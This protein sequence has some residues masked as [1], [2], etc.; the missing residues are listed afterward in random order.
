MP[1]GASE[2]GV[3]LDFTKAHRARLKINNHDRHDSR[4]SLDR[5]SQS[6]VDLH[7]TKGRAHTHTNRARLEHIVQAHFEESLFVK[8]VSPQTS[9]QS[10]FPLAACPLTWLPLGFTLLRFFLVKKVGW[11]TIAAKM[12]SSRGSMSTEDSLIWVC[13]NRAT[14]KM[15]VWFAVGSL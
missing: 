8:D 1:S 6:F 4:I 9:E 2:R 5:G 13:L 7:S 3:L 14:L 12:M 11:T 10:C 15:A